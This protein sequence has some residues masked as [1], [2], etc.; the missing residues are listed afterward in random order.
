[1]LDL[2]VEIRICG[3]YTKKDSK[4]KSDIQLR[5]SASFL[6][7]SDSQSIEHTGL[8]LSSYLVLFVLL[9]YDGASIFHGP[10]EI[11]AWRSPV[12]VLLSDQRW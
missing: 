7:Q 6:G 10:R 9:A 12:V 5:N 8:Y 11:G 4:W 3:V 2:V 1:M